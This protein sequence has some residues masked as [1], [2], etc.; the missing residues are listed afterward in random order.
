MRFIFSSILVAAL[1]ASAYGQGACCL[2]EGCEVLPDQIIC[3]DVF[4]GIWAGDNTD[5]TTVNCLSGACCVYTFEY[6][7]WDESLIEDCNSMGGEF[8]G[9]LSTCE[10]EGALCQSDVGACCID[11]NKCWDTVSEGKCYWMG[12]EFIGNDTACSQDAPWCV[13]YYGACCFGDSCQDWVEH[14]ECEMMGGIFWLD[15]C[16]DLQDVEMCGKDQP[17]CAGD[18][19]EN[20]TVDVDDLLQVLAVFGTSSQGDCDGDKDTDVDD[21]LLLIS[22]WGPCP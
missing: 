14:D 21:L 20:G 16:A 2:E 9:P 7:C 11:G 6:E 18:L 3:E 19:D 1:T 5:C 17:S 4:G 22:A 10:D 12:G 15:A 8:L 13:T